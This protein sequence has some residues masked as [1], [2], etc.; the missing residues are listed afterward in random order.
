MPKPLT[1]EDLERMSKAGCQVPGCQ[2]DHPQILY[3]H[4]RC[5][6][7]GRIEV[8]YTGGD[9]FLRIACRECGQI[10]ADIAVAEKRPSA[11]ALAE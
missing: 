1:K 11:Y 4:A 10:I 9:G 7:G 6:L 5:H 8:S 2:H 3:I